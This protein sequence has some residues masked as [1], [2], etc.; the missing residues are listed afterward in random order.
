MDGLPPRR[1]FED[2]EL[3]DLDDMDVAQ[4]RLWLDQERDAAGVAGEAPGELDDLGAELAGRAEPQGG[5]RFDLIQAVTRLGASARVALARSVGLEPSA[6]ADAPALAGLL[7]RPEHVAAAMG[8]LDEDARQLL[9][10]LAWAWH[11]SQRTIFAEHT[12][13]V[14]R[15]WS[16]AVMTE[17]VTRLVDQALIGH[18]EPPHDLLV[19]PTEVLDALP[20]AVL[21]HVALGRDPGPQEST[22][23]SPQ[24]VVADVARLLGRLR[25]G[26]PTTKQGRLTKR[27]QDGLRPL[28]TAR[29]H[30]ALIGGHR[31]WYEYDAAVALPLALAAMRSLVRLDRGRGVAEAT[32]AAERWLQLGAAEQWSSLV[33]A[34]VDILPSEDAKLA[35]VRPAVLGALPPDRWLDLFALADMPL[36]VGVDS[37]CQDRRGHLPLFVATGYRLGALAIADA[38]R[39]AGLPWVRAT[40]ALRAWAEGKP[41]PGLADLAG[42]ARVTGAGEVVVP[43]PLASADW[44]ELSAFCEVVSLDRAAILRPTRASVTAAAA[45]GLSADTLLR[46]LERLSGDTLPQA[47]AFQV[48]DWTRRRA[49]AMRVAVL[50]EAPDEAAALAVESASGLKAGDLERLRPGLWR[51]TPQ[52]MEAVREALAVQ[53]VDVDGDR[54]TGP[55]PLAGARSRPGSFHMPWPGPVEGMERLPPVPRSARRGSLP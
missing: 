12:F 19:V 15:R 52:R 16:H 49:V 28:V 18:V 37:L 1:R 33:E 26:V 35:L 48:R 45:A 38:E 36:T 8:R 9:Y 46:R 55:L 21:H 54:L 44:A 3:G 51:T 4:V 7:A 14:R 39:R 6:A 10:A 34:W 30:P 17:T 13:F 31:A 27:A 41:P 43:G 24:A 23:L 5:R 11:G 47:V 20:V 32:P 53:G 25:L 50:V 29:D 22:A 2:D 40:P 42:E